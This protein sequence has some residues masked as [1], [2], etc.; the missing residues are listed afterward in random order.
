MIDSIF[1]FLHILRMYGQNLTKC[2]NFG[3]IS[4]LTSD[5]AALKRLKNLYIRLLA[6]NRLH[7]ANWLDLLHSCRYQ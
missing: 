5:K 6:L 3:G 1:F 7:F 2:S 4:S